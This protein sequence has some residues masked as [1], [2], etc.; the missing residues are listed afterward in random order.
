MTLDY[1]LEFSGIFFIFLVKFTKKKA[2]LILDFALSRSQSTSCPHGT[3]YLGII[4]GSPV[5]GKNQDI[6]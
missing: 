4:L 1:C 5:G 3:V 6:R 2:L